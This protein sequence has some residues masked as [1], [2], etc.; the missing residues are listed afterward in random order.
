MSLSKWKKPNLRAKHD[1][2]EVDRA[3]DKVEKVT[4][5]E[6]PLKAKK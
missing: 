4:K 5:V 3:I 2:Q 1:A 6:K